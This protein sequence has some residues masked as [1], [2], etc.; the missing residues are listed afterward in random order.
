MNK[1]FQL[2]SIFL[3]TSSF[4]SAQTFN[5]TVNNGYGGGAFEA[6]E[7][8]HIFA[9][10]TSSNQIFDF[11]L[12]DVDFEFENEWHTK[13]I[14]P[15]QDVSVIA[16]YRQVPLFSFNFEQINLNSSSTK[17]Y[18]YL[19]P[20]VRGVIFLFHE[21]TG[22]AQDW[23]FR[24][25]YNKLLTDAVADSFG[26]VF[27]E[28]EEVTTQVDIDENG[29]FN[30]NTTQ[31]DLETN[32]DLKKLSLL[33]DTLKNRNLI[34]NNPKLYAVGKGNGGEFAVLLAN[35]LGFRSVVPYCAVGN[36]SLINET[37]VST[38]WCMAENDESTSVGQQG[39]TEAENLHN[40]IDAREICTRF[41]VHDSSPLYPER[42]L[43]DPSF[44]P[45]QISDVMADLESQNLIENNIMQIN[46]NDLLTQI[47]Q[48]PE[49]FTSFNEF[50]SAQRNFIAEQVNIAFAAHQFYSEYNRQTLE[51]F[52]SYCGIDTVFSHV[53]QLHKAAFNVK[54]YPNPVNNL[55]N[56][57]LEEKELRGL[58]Q[59][60]IFDAQ[61]RVLE[62][63]RNNF[64][65]IPFSSH[66][67]GMYYLRFTGT[68]GSVTKV[69]I[70]N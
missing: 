51:F 55:L 37:T 40:T 33:I 20:I 67:S 18:Y 38:Q 57:D 17:V 61:G 39:N 42:L 49:N 19:P 56:I 50:T 24:L 60:Q 10:E 2:F 64:N 44:S 3:F 52:K 23:L 7:V 41:Y 35:K 46:G 9:N 1:L 8:V 69:V 63:I 58:Q 13:F 30:W 32:T 16:V 65:Q 26:V 34:E 5:V 36:S 4:L 11:W 14:M 12:G 59:I 48:N 6:G 53:K 68:K 62:T 47:A 70:K 25:E 29:S 31:L 21:E 15:A 45:N 27:T 54:L 43:R 28:S 22:E 66:P